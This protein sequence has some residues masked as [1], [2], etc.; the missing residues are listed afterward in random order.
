MAGP[1]AQLSQDTLKSSHTKSSPYLEEKSSHKKE[2][3]KSIK[4]SRLQETLLVQTNGNC[5]ERQG[6]HGG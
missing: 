1:A 3:K 4:I 6:G 5:K 2:K